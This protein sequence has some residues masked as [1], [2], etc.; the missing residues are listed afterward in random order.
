MSQQGSTFSEAWH[1]VSGLRVS[2]RQTVTVQR[3]LY[4]GEKWYVLHDPFNNRFFR[5]TPPAYHFIAR[6]NREKTVEE[7][8][9]GSMEQFP[10]STPGQEE[11]LNLLGELYS[12]NLLAA[13][14]PLD[15]KRLFERYERN[16]KSELKA[17][18]W[19]FMFFRIPLFDPEPLL[20]RASRLISSM[21]S[22]ASLIVWIVTVLWAV[23][24]VIDN[25]DSVFSGAQGILAPGNLFLL[26]LALVLVKTIH[27]FGHAAVCH[28][29]GGEVH[30]MGLMFLL[31]TPLPYMDATS[32]WSFR[33]PWQ[34]A[35]VGGAG[36]LAELFVAAIAAFFWANTGDGPW[37]ALAYNIMFVASVSTVVFNA[38][39]LLRFDGYYIL[40]D[41]LD[42]PNLH[43]RA[44]KQ[45]Q[46]LV[47]GPVFGCPDSQSPAKGRHEALELTVYGVLSWGYR[48]LVFTG[49]ILF[50]ADRWLILGLIIAA[51]G[52][53]SWLVKPLVKYVKYLFKGPALHRCRNRA[54][55]VV[56]STLGLALILIATVPFPRYVV[57]PG[58]IESDPYVQVTGRAP[59]YVKQ[60]LVEPGARV[61]PGQPLLVLENRELE[62]MLL[63]AEARV[64]E[65]AAKER[66]ALRK[67]MIADLSPVRQQLQAARQSAEEL[68]DMQR[69]LVVRAVQP[70]VWVPVRKESLAGRWVDRGDYLGSILGSRGYRF[71]AVV[72]Q[73]D[74]TSI[75]EQQLE[76]IEV[77][78]WG[79]A[80]YG[81]E[82]NEVRR[83]PFQQQRLPSAALGWMGG[84][85]VPVSGDGSQDG[86][87]TTEPFFLVHAALPSSLAVAALH[88]R[89]G[90]IRF[91]LA[92]QPLL[93][94]WGRKVK[95][96]FQRRYQL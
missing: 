79:E 77:R 38:N 31:L 64:A 94:Q 88:G 39:P 71:S 35:L 23:K 74:V 54:V 82:V 86:L 72:S 26:Y 73:A 29:Y 13:E 6:L 34:R 11:V 42:I 15:S 37:H 81:V 55:G 50:V 68:R 57:A 48:I 96:V 32:S 2:L 70:G 5:L 19:S 14:V 4:R 61:H 92:S 44:D 43:K 63:K 90:R 16:R 75:F 30:T 1:L 69:H 24:V 3:Q 91:S 93:M 49:I 33:A 62:Y 21:V 52:I 17:K 12:M 8:W 65:F 41:L 80:G 95:Q 22:P 60:L 76:K 20:K 36:M 25:A 87:E 66:S 89:S 47:E 53:V 84:G 7:T 10:D 58:I 83:I 27:E 51:I 59:G 67:S 18:L 28:R 85:D 9:L 40:S 45:L 78:L 46:H 56:M